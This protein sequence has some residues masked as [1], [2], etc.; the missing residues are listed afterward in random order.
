MN[1]NSAEPFR[2]PPIFQVWI[3]A[4]SN[5]LS[6]LCSIFV[7]YYL[8][9]DR[10]LRRAL[11]NH[12]IVVLLILGFIYELTTVLWALHRR[13]YS[14][15]WINNETFYRFTFF[16]DYGIYAT[17]IT[18][19]AWATIERH[20]LIF[21]DGW[22]STRKQRFL[23]HYLPIGGILIYCLI[24]FSLVTFGP[25]CKQSFELY[26]AIDFYIPCT[27]DGTALGTWDLI[28]HQAVT[29]GFIVIFSIA[30][31][32]R[33]IQQKHKRNQAI[34]W[35]KYR[36][37]T[38]QLLSISSLYLVFNI[39][40]T[41]LIF[42][43]QYGVSADLIAIP[44]VFAIFFRIYVIFLFPFVCCASLPELRKKLKQFLL[45]HRRFRSHARVL[46]DHSL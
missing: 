46:P 13:L 8:L 5:A 27:F 12:I 26:L 1:K 37:M 14:T 43:S 15:P 32:I 2:I 19:F 21:H 38:I 11:N 20:I 10:T 9:F 42:A 18:L 29:T 44:M 30:L 33:V 28:F 4:I 23:I 31:L 16:I 41:V 7:L 22:I 17:Q 36:K 24:Y 45:I 25:F 35:K 39:P 6:I 34:Q 40:W 3:Y